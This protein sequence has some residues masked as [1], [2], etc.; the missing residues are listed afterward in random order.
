VRD[1]HLRSRVRVPLRAFHDWLQSQ[2]KTHNTIKQ[3]V[4]YA[5]RYAS[6]L[7]TGDAS[8][9][10]TLSARNKYHAMH[11]LANLAKFQDC[12]DLWLQIRQQY[13]LKCSSGNESLQS[14]ARFFD[15]SLNYDVILQRIKEMIC[16][17]LPRC[18]K[19]SSLLALL[20]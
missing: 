2:G 3:V 8:P 4:N 18:P 11:A 10:T 6:V 14:F 19:L 1:G 7:D 13:N 9:L 17:T 20:G 5:K 15:D 12:Y 16:K